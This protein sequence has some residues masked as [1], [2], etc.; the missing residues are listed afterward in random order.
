MLDIKAKNILFNRSLLMVGVR[1]A[2]L[3]S[4]FIFITFLAKFS[5][6]DVL[7]LYSLITV[8]V[9]YLLYILGFDFYTYSSREILKAG[10][11]LS[12]SYLYNQFTFYLLM[13]FATIPVVLIFFFAGVL[14]FTIL[15][16]F[17]ITLISEHL[18]QELMR[19]LVLSKNPFKANLQLFIRS[20]LWIYLYMAYSYLHA[21][22]SIKVMLV[23]WFSANIIAI[24][25]FMPVFTR[26]NWSSLRCKIDWAW[27]YKGVKI[28]IPLLCATLML[29]GIYI[30]DRYILKFTSTTSVLAVYSFYSN[31]ANALIAFVDAAVIMHYYPLIVESFQNKNVEKYITSIISFKKK[32]I[33][34]G[35]SIMVVLSLCMPFVCKVLGKNDFIEHIGIFYILLTSSFFY[36]YGL[37]YH[38]ELYARGKDWLI[39]ISTGL[40][41]IFC[42]ILQYIMAIYFEGVGVSLSVLFTSLLLLF[43]KKIM[44]ARVKRNESEI[45]CGL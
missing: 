45:Y 41:F 8:T 13:Y 31:I 42:I 7:A 34:I 24:V 27:V 14:P 21:D 16:L 33:S 28:A 22:Y 36:C 17:F 40:S 9:S 43:I 4:K 29:R 32:I 19:V 2:T 1:G 15:P 6:Y 37:V 23:M 30:S 11:E 26:V 5:S 20:S 39:V 38:Y 3:A 25:M 12:A 35:I 18:S 44:I 10:F